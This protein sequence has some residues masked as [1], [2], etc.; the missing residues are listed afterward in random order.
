MNEDDNRGNK[1]IRNVKRRLPAEMRRRQIADVAIDQIVQ[2]GVVATSA[3]QIAAAAGVSEA[4]LY[5]HFGSRKKVLEAAL[6]L[7]YE[8]LSRE[9]SAPIGANA[10]EQLRRIDQSHERAISGEK[11]IFAALFQFYV[12]PPNGGMTLEVREHA[13]SLASAIASVVE[14]GKIEGV[15]REDVDSQSTAWKL[16]SVY[17]FRD[18]SRLLGLDTAVVSGTARELLE[19]TL[20]G[21]A[22][23]KDSGGLK[24]RQCPDAVRQCPDAEAS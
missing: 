9:V 24:M 8:E 21:I 19:N 1:P 16:T 10:L 2:N 6:D 13:L 7:I 15:I 14:R 18:V 20:A 22:V 3:V 12:A 17:W 5:H 23:G 4:A 11:R